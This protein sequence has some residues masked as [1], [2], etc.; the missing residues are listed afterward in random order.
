L[1]TFFI[2]GAGKA[3]TTSLHYYLSQHPDILMSEP[4]EPIFFRIEYERGTDYYWRTYFRQWAGQRHVGDADP[5]NLPLPFVTTRIAATV[6]DARF[7]ILCRNPVDRIVSNWWQNTRVG[8]E[9][10]SFEEAVM[11][12]LE[13]LEKGPI[14][15]D[16][17]AARHY[18]QVF[19]D[20]GS[21]GLVRYAAYVDAGYYAQHAERYAKAFGRD[22]V[23]LLFTEDLERDPDEVT[24]ECVRFLGL[25]PVR[26]RDKRAQHVAISAGTAKALRRIANFPGVGRIPLSWRKP[27]RGLVERFAGNRGR[28]GMPPIPMAVRQMLVEHYRPHN[29]RLAQLTGRDLSHWNELQRSSERARQHERPI[30]L[31][32]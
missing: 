7:V 14:F 11:A 20:S 29:E 28:S 5:R 25:D 23:K 13:R 32:V 22:R 8:I 17:A 30:P 19:A 12:N 4:K 2:L 6:P 24:A 31:A 10:R 15:I 26:L 27:V 3:G 18:A 1:P 9:D 16:E 21:R